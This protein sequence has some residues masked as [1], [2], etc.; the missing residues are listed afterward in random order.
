MTNTPLSVVRETLHDHALPA[1]LPT[2]HVEVRRITMPSGVAAGTHRH[3]GPVFGVIE[4]GSVAFQIDGQAEQI[5][6]VG[7]VFYEPA[8]TAI[9]R[10]DSRADGAVFLGYFLLE[11]GQGPVLESLPSPVDA[12]GGPPLG[13]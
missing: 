2:A 5:L 9:S 12:L 6:H 1:P 3:N 8:D 4:Q 13:D 7:D 10:F 11:S